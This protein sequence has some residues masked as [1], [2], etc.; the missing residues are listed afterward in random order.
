MLGL[1][2][3]RRPAE[4]LNKEYPT[5]AF[6]A[7]VTNPFGKSALIQLLR[8]FAQLLSNRQHV[9]IGLVGYP[10][11]G[12]SSVINA[13]KMKKV[14][15]AAPVP[16]ET[17]V[18]QYISLT[19][20]IFLIDCPGIV[21]PTSSDFAEDS[22]K[23]LKGVVRVEKVEYPSNYIPEV[24]ERV[25]RKYI[26]SKYGFPKDHDAWADHEEFLTQLAHKKGKLR[27]GGEPDIEIVARSVLYDWQRGRIPFFVAPPVPEGDV[28]EEEAAPAADGDAPAPVQAFKEL[29]CAQDF[30]E[31][32]ARGGVADDEP[33]AA[34]AAKPAKPAEAAEAA[35]AAEDAE[36]PKKGKKRKA[37]EKKDGAKK[38]KPKKAKEVAPSAALDWN[39]VAAEFAA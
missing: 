31:E 39:A 13:L 28:E 36:A 17:K 1:P 37:E 21:P 14:C 5:V 26:L 32:D 34:K 2:A 38:K 35:E 8:Q 33:A 15:K 9:Q 12:K 23:V 25:K 4:I 29:K 16:G 11:V 7:S 20:R 30:D 19:K 10:N 22:A 27:K 3:T 24:L 6:H 18:W